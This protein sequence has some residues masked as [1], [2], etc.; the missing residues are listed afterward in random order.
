MVVGAAPR[1]AHNNGNPPQPACHYLWLRG[2]PDPDAGLAG[3]P[4]GW[5]PAP[6]PDPPIT[7]RDSHVA[8][9]GPS[10]SGRSPPRTGQGPPQGCRI[11]VLRHPDGFPQ[12]PQC[13]VGVL[14]PRL[15]YLHVP[16]VQGHPGL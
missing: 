16:L 3:K 6:G 12:L 4:P 8:A 2:E 7:V 10:G 14:D 1:W 11:D 13:R 5:V 15:Q 9:T